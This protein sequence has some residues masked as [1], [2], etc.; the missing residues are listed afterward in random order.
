MK[1]CAVLGCPNLAR[2][3]NVEWCNMHRQR[4]R[5]HGDPLHER[6]PDTLT[7]VMRRIQKGDCWEWTGALFQGTGYGQVWADG[8]T[9]LA[10]RVVYELLVGPIPVGLDLDHLCRNRSCVNPAHLEPVTRRV[11]VQRG[12][13]A[14]RVHHRKGDT[15]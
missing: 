13:T 2:S 10:H 8:T 12:W 15:A 6:W 14:G 4:V 11:N 5:K 3:S 7:R 1:P 9:R